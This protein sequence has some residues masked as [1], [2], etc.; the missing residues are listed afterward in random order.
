MTSRPHRLT[1]SLVVLAAAMLLLLPETCVSPAGG[2]AV[3]GDDS[4]LIDVDS[5]TPER[6]NSQ[7]RSAASK[8]TASPSPL[9]Y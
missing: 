8:S 2:F 4:P 3:G 7:R 1:I 6:T 9:E 5:I